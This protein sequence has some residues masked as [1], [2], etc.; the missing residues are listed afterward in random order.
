[1]RPVAILALSARQLL[2]SP[3]K[4]IALV[5]LLGCN[6]IALRGGMNELKARQERISTIQTDRAEEHAK[7]LGW[8]AEGKKGPDESP[9]VDMSD[10]FWCAWYARPKAI[11][12]PSPL[13]AIAPGRSADNPWY[14]DLAYFS[15]AYSTRLQTEIADPEQRQLGGFDWVFV[16]IYLSPLFLLAL[17]FDVGGAERDR[18]ALSLIRLLTGGIRGWLAWRLV[19]PVLA[20]WLVTMAPMVVASVQAGAWAEHAPATLTIVALA[21]AYLLFWAA[22]LLVAAWMAQGST[23]QALRGAIAYAAICLVLPGAIQ[24]G[25]KLRYP[26]SLMVDY[27]TADRIGAQAVYELEPDTISRRFYAARPELRVTP[28]GRD[29]VPDENIDWL[30]GSTLVSLMMDSVVKE[31]AESERARIQAMERATWWLPS[32]AVPM[33][34]EKAA[35]TSAGHHLAF[36]MDVQEGG[37]RILNKVIEDCWN[38]RQMDADGFKEHVELIIN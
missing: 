14:A 38:K 37:E 19:V 36:R 35:G 18:G 6:I 11:L 9:W 13:L 16:L 25:V 32:M 24:W 15:N 28:H 1:M 4:L 23:D 21:T 3:G 17:V 33:A 20:V 10:P 12:D 26:P 2:R 8:F 31:V 27:I 30:M 5:L 22:L 34:M 7:V 29:N